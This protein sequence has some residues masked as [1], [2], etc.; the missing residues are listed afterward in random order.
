MTLREK[1]EAGWNPRF[2]LWCESR[3]FQPDSFDRD[4][5]EDMK[6]VTHHNG[7]GV[8][9]PWTLVFSDWI[10][11]QW[12]EWAH[13]IGFKDRDGWQAHRLAQAAGHGHAEFDAWLRLKVKGA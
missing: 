13:S 4:E 2:V 10:K 11:A 3:G 5:D 8:Q 7:D 9:Y 1:P 12:K 6:L